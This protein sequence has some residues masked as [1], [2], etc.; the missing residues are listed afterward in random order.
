[1]NQSQ[2]VTLKIYD[3]LGSEVVTLV[4]EEKTAGSYEVD[5]DAS[6]LTSGVYF[7]KLHSPGFSKSGKLI[8]LK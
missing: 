8:K 7:Y 2:L 1:M 3:L 4:N 6:Q 5:L